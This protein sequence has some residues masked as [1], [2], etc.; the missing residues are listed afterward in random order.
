MFY[1]LK[2]K[3]VK[4]SLQQAPEQQLGVSQNVVYNLQNDVLTGKVSPKIA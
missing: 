4:L 2:E 1:I 3:R